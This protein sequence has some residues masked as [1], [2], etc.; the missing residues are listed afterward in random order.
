MQREGE[1]LS[2]SRSLWPEQ[3]PFL[4]ALLFSAAG[5]ISSPMFVVCWF[6]VYADHKRDVCFVAGAVIISY[7]HAFAAFTFNWIKK[8]CFTKIT[9][10]AKGA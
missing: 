6:L 10:L 2:L 9:K 8:H 7:F 5:Q 3:M 4:F 1:F